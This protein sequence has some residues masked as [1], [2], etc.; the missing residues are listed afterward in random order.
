MAEPESSI[1]YQ[2]QRG[3]GWDVVDEA[4][5]TYDEWMLDDDFEPYNILRKIV[6]RMRERRDLYRSSAKS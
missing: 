4:L 2:Q 1:E 5:E 6:E 3:A